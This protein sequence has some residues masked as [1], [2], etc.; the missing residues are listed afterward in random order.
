MTRQPP[1]LAGARASARHAARAGAGARRRRRRRPASGGGVG[2]VAAAAR[3]A[4][5]RVRQPH[6]GV[7]AVG[8]LPLRR[9][10]AGVGSDE[11]AARLC[12][13]ARARAREEE[14]GGARARARGVGRRREREARD[15]SRRRRRAPK[16]S[17]EEI[18]GARCSLGEGE[19]ASHLVRG[20]AQHGEHARRRRPRLLGYSAP[21]AAALARACTRRR[22]GTCDVGATNESNL[23]ERRTS[24][25][26]AE[27]EACAR[28][29]RAVSARAR[30][31][32]FSHVG[33]EIERLLEPAAGVE[34]RDRRP[35]R[36]HRRASRP[37]ASRE[38]GRSGGGQTPSPSPPVDQP[39]ARARPRAPG[40]PELGRG[41]VLAERSARPAATAAA[42]GR[43]RGAQRGVVR[44][45]GDT[46]KRWGSLR[47]PYVS[48]GCAFR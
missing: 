47:S 11:P 34:R 40:Q 10:V 35:R 21:I 17:E 15:S 13:R 9:R 2:G 20:V 3:A 38:S 31:R 44:D 12:A 5:G 30:R 7:D 39:D 6:D 8:R 29:A 45:G 33:I 27:T 23:G 4:G 16:R 43:G 48:S 19:G 26:G 32:A 46:R 22:R 42:H 28:R 25:A 37:R 18:E 24:E 41:V 1:A 36:A 14:R